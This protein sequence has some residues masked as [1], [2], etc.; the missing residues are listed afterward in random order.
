MKILRR[1]KQIFIPKNYKRMFSYIKENGL[2][3]LFGKIVAG[4]KALPLDEHYNNWFYE[5]AVTE[6]ELEKQRNKKFEFEPLISLLV[7]T[8]NTPEDMLKE[9]VDSIREQSYANWELC[10]ADGSSLERTREI[11]KEYVEMDDR[12]K[13]TYLDQNYGISGNT[14]KA[15]E[16]ATG[17]FIGL[18]D[19]DDTVEPDMLYE[20]VARLQDSKVDMVY[21][22]EDKLTTQRGYNKY[23]H[24]NPIFKPDYS[25]DLLRSHNYIT[26]FLVIRSSIVNEVG[27]FDSEFDGA[28]DYNLILNCVEVIHKRGG[29]IEHVPRIL[30]HWRM[31]KGSTAENPESKMY[32]YESG[33]KAIETH[34]HRL[35]IDATVEMTDMWGLYHPIYK[36][37]GDPLLSIIIPNK[38]HIDD[39]DKCIKSLET[40]NTYKNIE[41]IVVENNSES[42]E[43]FDYYEKLQ[44][45]F[46][47][48]KVVTW[49]K[50]FNYSAINNFGAKHAKGE[51]FLLL[52]NDTE[53]ISPNGIADMLGILLRDDVGIVGAKL[54]YADDTIQ[55]AGI[56]L[57][58]QH[59]AGHVFH[60]LPKDDY[61][62]MM[63]PRINCNY[64]AVTG[65]CL[66][67]KKSV[68]DEVE[69]L[70][71]DF[72]VAGNDVDFCLKVR[73]K[74]YLVV[75]DAFA[76]FHHY[77]SKSRGYEDTPEKQARFE[78]ERDKFYEKWKDV[79]D[80]GDPYY[81]KNFP[82]TIAPFTLP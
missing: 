54:L 41:I 71:E 28:Q 5:H 75:Y 72:P 1:V 2:K 12:I 11:L 43:T 60:T 21:T 39:L 46:S 36:T 9:M 24:L 74:G 76:L 64:S 37:V 17:D 58:F 57:G 56:V 7:P 66:M 62:Y 15:L 65:A 55:H 27:G 4:F 26:H 32:A 51:Y 63:R 38:D 78:K 80:A 77:E 3:G 33:R 79:L 16:L 49:E 73:D 42:Q 35:G 20:V 45:E 30:Y 23:F 14:N 61:G 44:T 25:P 53:V 47:N 34:L 40:V 19:H 13:V 29:K 8:Y 68:F 82:V 69:G 67:V 31:T 10:I 18:I 48:V 70:S 50:E 81:N 52:N 22:D 59:Y 6:E